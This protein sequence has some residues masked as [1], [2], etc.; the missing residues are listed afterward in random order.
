MSAASR[1]RDRA[2]TALALAALA[3]FAPL[4][5]LSAPAAAAGPSELRLL[6]SQ[7]LTP[8]LQELTFSTPALE[9]PTK[10][11]VLLPAGYDASGAARYPVLL[12]LHGAN[13]DHTAW[14]VKGNAE[15]ITAGY[16]LIVVMPDGGVDGGY[17]DWYNGGSYGPPRWES[18]HVGQ[19]LPWIDAHYRTVGS[20]GARAVAGVSMGGGGSM[21]YAAAHPELFA[22]AASFSGA[23]DD[24]NFYQQKLVDVTGVVDGKPPGSACGLWETDQ[25]RCRGVN[26]TD[27][28]EN[29]GGLFLQL[30]SGNGFPGGPNGNPPDLIESGVHEQSLTLH[31][32]LGQLG[33]P[34]VWDDYGPG[35]HEYFYFSRD[36][37][38]LLPRLMGVFANPPAPPLPFNFTSVATAYG[39]YG[40]QV[41][42][43]RPAVEFSELRGAGPAGFQLR[44]S[45]SARVSTAPYYRPRQRL[46]V[47]VRNREG[48]TT[49]TLR[50]D[51][52][53]RLSLALALGP[54]NPYQQYSPQATAWLATR[55]ATEV[56]GQLPNGPGAW[57]VYEAAVVVTAAHR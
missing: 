10:V 41:A 6:A 38:A 36:L 40:W 8:R 32:R 2:R 23:V 17:T 9:G 52:S 54:A 39:P 26:P 20:R 55:N 34:H 13:E 43:E 5:P 44:G 31:E 49:R 48:D 24:G 47:R 57:P 51:R 33:I 16:P 45:G 14:T 28:A 1:V 50:A 56:S 35:G 4:A 37:Q 7:S 19:L 25:V 22:A 30:D 27:L 3:L 29:L 11:R 18:Y 12:L 15:A 46:K 42:I 53:G 21:H